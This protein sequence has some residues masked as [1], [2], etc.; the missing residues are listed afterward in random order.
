MKRWEY[1]VQTKGRF[2]SAPSAGGI[3]VNFEELKEFDELLKEAC[4][5]ESYQ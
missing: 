4:N 5:K 1:L 2:D 3:Q